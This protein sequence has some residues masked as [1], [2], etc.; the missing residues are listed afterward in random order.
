MSQELYPRS[1]VAVD[2]LIGVS[3]GL[4]RAAEYYEHLGDEE[5]AKW[6]RRTR[7]RVWALI[8]Q[9]EDELAAETSE[10]GTP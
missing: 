3:S 9:I 4:N 1:V 2:G 6:Y 10:A 8:N 7:R 5:R